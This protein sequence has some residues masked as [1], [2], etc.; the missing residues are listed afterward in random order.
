MSGASITRSRVTTSAE[1]VLIGLVPLLALFPLHNN[2]LWWH[3]ATGKWI[4]A[5]HAVPRDDIFAWTRYLTGWIDNEWL[6]QV[7][8][9]GAWKAGGLRALIVFRALL[10]AAIA[11]LLRMYTRAFALAIIPAVALSWHWWELRPSVFSLIGLLAMLVLIDRERRWWLPPLF[12]V[13]ANLHPGFV[14]GLVVLIA[15]SVIPN[16]GDGEES[17]RRADGSRRP[18]SSLRLGTTAASLVAT[19]LN[20]YG[21]RVYEQSLAIGSNREYRA[22]LDEWLVPPWWFLLIA[23]AV[24]LIGAFHV[25]RLPLVRLMPLFATATLSMT[26]VRFEE[27]LAWI[28][29]PIAIE[30]FCVAP[31][32]SAAFSRR[33]AAV[34]GGATLVLVFIVAFTRSDVVQPGRYP[35]KCMSAV[36]GKVFNRLSWGGWLIWQGVP[37][38]IDGRCSGQKLFFDFVAA[39]VKYARPLLARWGID[40][41]IVGADDGTLK[42]L[43]NAPEWQLVCRDEASFV[44]WRNPV[45]K[46]EFAP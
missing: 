9:Y 18:D 41:V 42:Q 14:F 39:Q 11:V 36:K 31:P 38:F 45:Q 29:L 6:S 16:R 40:T 19:L 46:R 1:V 2:D 30:C 33:F 4:A 37:P 15:M 7:L 23:V 35:T 22:L 44:F 28:A 12:L 34:A 26:A 27:Y 25:R 43:A 32:T 24:L 20:P 13:W 8:F 21:W 5:H 17:G 10:L 3:L